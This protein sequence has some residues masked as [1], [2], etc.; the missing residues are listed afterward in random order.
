MDDQGYRFGV[1]VL[2]VASMVIAVI[3]IL[4]FGA[5]P[6]FFVRRY[7]VTI[8][9]QAAPGVESDTPVRKNGV[10]IG[11]VKSVQLLDEEGVDLTLELDDKYTV[12]ARELPQIGKGSLIT[13]DA[14][15]EFVPPTAD[16]L[17]ARFDGTGGSPRDGM[18]DENEMLLASTPIKDGDFFRGG[19][20]APDPLD[21]LLNMQEGFGSTLSAI[22]N[23]GNQVTALAL[24]VRKLLGSGD[25][26][27]QDLAR[28]VDLTVDNFNNTLNAIE[29]LFDD[30]NLKSSLDTLAKRLPDIVNEAEAVMKQTGSTLAAFEDVGRAAEETVKGVTKTIHHVNQLTEP[31]GRNGEKL[32]G[33]AVRTLDNLDA[34]LTDL[35]RVAARFNNSQGTVAKLMDDPQLYYTIVNTLDNVETL[36]RKLEPIV[37]D[38]RVFSD[39]VARQ[40]SSLIDLRGAIHGRPLGAGIK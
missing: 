19:R 38:V 7:T 29:G 23:A 26:A 27:M 20:V 28:K 13:G 1:G 37:N 33:D 35:R 31:L 14:V 4:F 32:V 3:L 39:K 21:A 9:F 11:R 10:Q 16:S 36:T 6:N 34:L 2:V 25:G 18:L 22:E 17:V 24:D 30:P 5:A 40:P 8:R 15:V 12:R